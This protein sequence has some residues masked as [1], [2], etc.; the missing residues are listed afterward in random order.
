MENDYNDDIIITINSTLK[1][2][3]IEI[4]KKNQLNLILETIHQSLLDNKL[5]HLHSLLKSTLFFKNELSSN[6]MSEQIVVDILS[7]P[8]LKAYYT[9]AIDIIVVVVIAMNGHINNTGIIMSALISNHKHKRCIKA[10]HSLVPMCRKEFNDNILYILTKTDIDISYLL[11]YFIPYINIDYKIIINRYI[12]NIEL[13]CLLME[14]DTIPYKGCDPGCGKACVFCT[15]MKYYHDILLLNINDNFNSHINKFINLYF[16]KL[17]YA[18]IR[19]KKWKNINLNTSLIEY[20]KEDIKRGGTELL[21]SI[22]YFIF[23]YF[24]EFT[25]YPQ[26]IKYI[27]F[28]EAVDESLG[29]FKYARNIDISLFL[30]VVSKCSNF[31]EI[32]NVLPS[33]CLYFT[34]KNKRV[35]ELNC[36]IYDLLVWTENNNGRPLIYNAIINYIH[37]HM[38]NIKEMLVLENPI[39]DSSRILLALKDSGIR[40]YIIG[41]YLESDTMEEKKVLEYLF[42]ID[43]CNY[44]DRLVEYINGTSDPILG[45]ENILQALK[46]L[47]FFIDKISLIGNYEFLSKILLVDHKIVYA[48]LSILLE[49]KNV[50]CVCTFLFNSKIRCVKRVECLY[51]VYK[52]GC[53]C[54]KCDDCNLSDKKQEFIEKLIVFF[55]ECMNYSAKVRKETIERLSMIYDNTI[56]E[57]MLSKCDSVDILKLI[58][59]L[60]YNEV[61]LG[62][63]YADELIRRIKLERKNCKVLVYLLGNFI[64]KYGIGESILRELVIRYR[65]FVVKQLKIVMKERVM[66][67]K[68]IDDPFWRKMVY[69]KYTEMTKRER[70]ELYDSN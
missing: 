70:E 59:G 51:W 43:S 64:K 41:V 62:I 13:I 18:I 39:N 5:T 11:K 30:N 49:K 7:N 9:R 32:I 3:N 50:G 4:T 38:H 34:D 55:A 45:V 15:K 19:N 29:I 46:M 17:N 53:E 56:G 20:I 65:K 60:A 67:G 12:K 31:E 2:N 36:L 28:E 47:I 14:A 25:S 24:K 16:L 66:E 44:G 33:V 21:D 63:E 61:D 1:E 22:R 58:N 48:L 69:S 26:L 52:N 37:S 54:W 23:P 40:E 42:N 6:P 10:L 68:R 27:N 57:Y 8:K 35:Q